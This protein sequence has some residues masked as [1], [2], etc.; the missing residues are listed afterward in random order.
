M[1]MLQRLQIGTKLSTVVL[2]P[3]LSG[4]LWPHW[5]SNTVIVL[6]HHVIVHFPIYF[7]PMYFNQTCSRNAFGIF[8]FRIVFS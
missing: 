1:L 6:R 4:I 7:R 3:L 5:K 2:P 8:S